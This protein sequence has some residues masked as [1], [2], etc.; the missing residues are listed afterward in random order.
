VG[1]QDVTRGKR[2]AEP[3][4]YFAME[5]TMLIINNAQEF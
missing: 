5:M 1:V 3:G 2:R 4:T